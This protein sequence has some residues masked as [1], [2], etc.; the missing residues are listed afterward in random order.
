MGSLNGFL[1]HMDWFQLFLLLIGAV[2]CLF[3][4]T[5][6]ELAHGWPTSWGTPPPR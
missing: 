2:A 1:E 5:F 3:C 6:H 4:I